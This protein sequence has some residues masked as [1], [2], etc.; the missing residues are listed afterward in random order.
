MKNINILHEFN[1]LYIDSRTALRVR[2][3][4]RQQR[5]PVLDIRWF[6]IILN[7]W[8]HFGV[9]IPIKSLAKLSIE[10]IQ[11]IVKTIMEKE[12]TT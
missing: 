1:P 3:V 9:S 7:K 12:R 11:N 5:A 4:S 2:L 10:C 6:D 8:T